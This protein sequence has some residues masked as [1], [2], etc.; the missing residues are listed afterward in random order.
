MWSLVVQVKFLGIGS[1]HLRIGS[2]GG[3]VAERVHSREE[4]RAFHQDLL[5]PL[6][7]REVSGKRPQQ[8]V[9]YG[10]GDGVRGWPWR[11]KGG[12]EDLQC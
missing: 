11:S 1:Q 2:A 3:G 9:C 7:L 12:G 6:G 10:A 8:E 5:R 4:C